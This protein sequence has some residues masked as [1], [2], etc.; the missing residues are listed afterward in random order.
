[1]YW[2][3]DKAQEWSSLECVPPKIVRD[4]IA[5]ENNVQKEATDGY[6]DMKTMVQGKINDRRSQVYLFKEELE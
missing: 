6:A 2:R 5:A 3:V 4:E 1:M